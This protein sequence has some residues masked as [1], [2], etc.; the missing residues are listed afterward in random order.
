MKRIDWLMECAKDKTALTRAFTYFAGCPYDKD[1]ECSEWTACK[2]CIRKYL[3]QESS[4][5]EADFMRYILS[6]VKK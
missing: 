5:R 4:Q 3:N 2:D 6:G 1:Y